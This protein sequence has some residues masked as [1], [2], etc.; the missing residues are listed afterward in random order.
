MLD[1]VL[2]AGIRLVG[3]VRFYQVEIRTGWVTVPEL[4]LDSGRG[5]GG[6]AREKGG[7]SPAPVAAA[8]RPQ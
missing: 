3:E 8:C 2:S 6:G 5:G 1:R 7:L 4:Q